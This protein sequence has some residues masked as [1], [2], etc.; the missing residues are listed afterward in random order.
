M[1]QVCLIYV[2]A[3]LLL[4]SGCQMVITPEPP[5][6]S[7]PVAAAEATETPEA[8]AVTEGAAPEGE[9]LFTDPAGRFTLPVP[10][11]WTAEAKEGYVLVSDP[12]G[13]IGLMFFVVEGMGDDLPAAAQ[14]TWEM[15]DLDFDLAPAFTFDQPAERGWEASTIIEYD[16]SLDEDGFFAAVNRRYQGDA[17]VML[18]RTDF[19][20]FQERR[21]Q[22]NIIDTGWR[23]AGLELVDLSGRAPLPVTNEIVAELESFIETELEHFGLPG[24][25]VVVVQGGE[26]VYAGGFGVKE[27][28]GTE[29]VTPE[30]RMLIHSLSKSMTTMMMAS[31]VDNG[32][33]AWDTPVQEIL[34][35]FTLADP[36]LSKQLT[37]RDTACACTGIPGRFLEVNFNWNELSAEAVIESLQTYTPTAAYGESYQYSNQMVVLG[38]YAAAAAAGGEVGKLREEYVAEMEQRVF[39]PIGMISTTF[40]FEEVLAGDYAAPHS[41]NAGSVY[42]QLSP[43]LE[44]SLIPMAPA[45]GVWSNALDMGRYL[46]TQLNRGVAPDGTQVISAEN[47]TATW[48]PQIATGADDSYAVGL[49]VGSYKGVPILGHSGGN[50]GYSSYMVFLPEAELGLVLLTNGDTGSALGRALRFRLLELVYEQPPEAAAQAEIAVNEIRTWTDESINSLSEV[51]PAAVEPLLGHYGNELLGEIELRL[52]DGKF[53]FDA[54]EFTIELRARLNDDGTVERYIAYAPILLGM[55]L[56][57]TATAG[58]TIELT[59]GEG[60]DSYIFTP[61]E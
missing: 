60:T 56:V 53:M 15:V 45:G 39:E 37:L 58:G 8:G 6:A 16:T 41:F 20:T 30:T 57:P 61:I 38:G 17:Y 14:A 28:G 55:P 44:R 40:S 18:V 2:L 59:L 19:A 13:L 22:V 43:D 48:E 49:S 52:E 23:V 31:L 21:A 27:A 1:K 24:A 7:T 33:V 5:A 25:A 10:A 42:L 35:Q 29:P 3:T 34:P 32:L 12:D 26:I 36:V 4:L 54:G 9:Q 50:F 46:I 11:D 47:L 51:D